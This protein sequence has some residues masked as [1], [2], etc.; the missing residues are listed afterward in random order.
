MKEAGNSISQP[1]I[2]SLWTVLVREGRPGLDGL[3][4]GADCSFLLAAWLF[5]SSTAKGEP[6]NSCPRVLAIEAQ[7]A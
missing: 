5:V 6:A 1:S 2:T 3:F 7:I 4:T